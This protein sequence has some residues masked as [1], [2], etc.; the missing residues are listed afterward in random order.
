[1]RVGVVTGFRAEAAV[2]KRDDAIVTMSGG[3]PAKSL[4]LAEALLREGIAGLMSFG[5]AG[6]LAPRVAPGTL[7]LATGIVD[8]DKVRDTDAA[9][10]ARLAASLP[11]A[12]PGRILAGE[13]IIANASDK[14]RLHLETGALAVDMESGPVALAASRANIP[15]M[16]IRAIADPA[17]RSLPPAALVG[18]TASGGYAIGAIL[19]SL[20]LEPRQLPALI[21][22]ARDSRRGLDALLRG[23][24]HL[25]PGLGL[26]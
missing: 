8:R 19:R 1:M 4:T 7:V 26:G 23:G 22:L 6:G 2:L 11:E 14:R 12:V 15:F 13:R 16:A 20:L 3:D 17:E 21:R 5:L 18:L 9:W 25:G 24:A 10:L